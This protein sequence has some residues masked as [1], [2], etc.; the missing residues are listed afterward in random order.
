MDRRDN[1]KR[2]RVKGHWDNLKLFSPNAQVACKQVV[3]G[4]IGLG[5]RGKWSGRVCHEYCTLVRKRSV[6]NY[7]LV[8]HAVF[9][10]YT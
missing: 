1:M 8:F 4:L 6:E 5:S 2:A 10:L 9:L 3:V 7:P